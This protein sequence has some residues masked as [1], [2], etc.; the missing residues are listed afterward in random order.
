MELRLLR[1]FLA[2]ADHESISKAAEQLHITQP[3]LSRQL[4]GLE[5]HLGVKLFNRDQP[6]RRVTL[7][8]A[9]IYLRRRAVDILQLADDTEDTLIHHVSGVIYITT[10][11]SVLVSAL[12]SAVQE[13]RKTLPHVCLYLRSGDLQDAEDHLD[14]GLSDF[15]FV[16][17]KV[18]GHKY[19]FLTL[20]MRSVCGIV[21]RKDAPLADRDVIRQGDLRDAPLI[22]SRQVQHE[23]PFFQWMECDPTELNVVGHFDLAYNAGQ[24]AEAGLGYVLSFDQAFDIP[25]SSPLCFRPLEPKLEMEFHLIWKKNQHYS[26]DAQLF[27]EQARMSFA[28]LN[29]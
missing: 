25:K 10:D 7:T 11:E 29:G 6:H 24:M 5:E 2:V 23:H 14:R 1:Y 12:A 26:K 28:A 13:L 16:R 4:I 19:H 3:T 15:G 8:E 18:D 9:G 27:L 17:G 20:P 22:L 21:M